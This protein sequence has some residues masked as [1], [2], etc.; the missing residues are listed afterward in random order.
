VAR[1]ASQG[2][3]SNRTLVRSVHLAAQDRLNIALLSAVAVAIRLVLIFTYRPLLGNDSHSYIDLAH[4]LGSMHLEG[5]SGSR[6]PG[7]PLLL[8]AVGYSPVATWCVQAALGVIATL[9]VYGLV[10]RLGGGARIALVAAL[11]YTLSFEVLAVE[12]T[13]LTETLASFLLLVAAH[14]AVTIVQSGRTRGASALFLGLTLA[15]LCLV[16][17]DALAVTVYLALAVAVAL[18]VARADRPGRRRAS[19]A[20]TAF[21]ILTPPLLVLAAWAGVNR[22]TIGITSVSTVIGHNMIDHVAAEV[23]VTPGPDH[24]ITSAYV[25]ARV[26]RE[27]HTRDLGNLS[28][29][30]ELAMERASHLDAAHLSGRLLSIALGVIERHPFSYISSS[31]EQWP[32]FWLPPNYADEFTGGLGSELIRLLW[33]LERAVLAL[34]NVV[35]VLLL[36]ADLVQRVRRHGGILARAP[37]VLAGIPIIGV[38]PATFFA[39]GETGRYGYVYFPLVIGVTFA[40]AAPLL[41]ALRARLPAAHGRPRPSRA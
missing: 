4:R 36:V 26:R 38:L 22:A 27:A 34:I 11:V 10:R 20:R 35:F 32:R 33:R 13:V 14:F 9:L 25:A 17:P 21:A 24:S 5:A 3:A 16:R 37:L 8:L 15:Y 12:R 31:V 6:T 40:I 19:A 18:Y 30:A 1:R 39:Y 7:Y 29:D 41:R 28:Y 2:G 23:R